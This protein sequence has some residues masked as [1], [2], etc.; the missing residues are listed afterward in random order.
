MPKS[1]TI[2]SIH[3]TTMPGPVPACNPFSQKC[4]DMR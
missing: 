1:T 2:A 3:G 4:P